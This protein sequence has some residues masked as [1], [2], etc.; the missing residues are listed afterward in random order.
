LGSIAVRPT[1]ALQ[2]YGEHSAIFNGVSLVGLTV[3]LVEKVHFTGVYQ[4]CI[5]L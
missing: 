3:V 5:E 2:L 4:T 1:G